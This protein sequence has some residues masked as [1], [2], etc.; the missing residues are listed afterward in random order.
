MSNKWVVWWIL[1]ELRRV[2]SR[3]RNS[4]KSPN[5]IET[6]YI[7]A[8]TGFL[9]LCVDQQLSNLD[10]DRITEVHSLTL[11]PS[12]G[13]KKDRLSGGSDQR[14]CLLAQFPTPSTTCRLARLP[15]IHRN[16]RQM[17]TC[18]GQHTWGLL[19][20]EQNH[21][22]LG[23]VDGLCPSCI[24]GNSSRWCLL[25]G[26][27]VMLIW[28]S[29]KLL[30]GRCAPTLALPPQAYFLLRKEGLRCPWVKWVVSETQC[31]SSAPPASSPRISSE[32]K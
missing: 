8:L 21:L 28:Y 10:T 15:W 23:L 7:G 27:L 19:V 30:E 1:V 3:V 25:G 4:M 12:I 16:H 20:L 26:V 13:L 29:E 9:A 18:T 22:D 14:G 32:W 17:F 6:C 24:N 5:V 11:T 31:W 2:V